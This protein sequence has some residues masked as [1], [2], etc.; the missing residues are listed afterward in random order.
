MVLS[1]FAGRLGATLLRRLYKKKNSALVTLID[2]G[3]NSLIF[4]HFG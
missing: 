3:A 2:E 4:I 1:C